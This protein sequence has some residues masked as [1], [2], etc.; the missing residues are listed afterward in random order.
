MTFVG[1]AHQRSESGVSRGR[2][3]PPEVGGLAGGGR[4]GPRRGGP[5][6]VWPDH[7]GKNSTAGGRRPTDGPIKGSERSRGASSSTTRIPLAGLSTTSEDGSGLPR[8][9]GRISERRNA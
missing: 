1:D 8:R 3:T 7:Q 2:P 5:S 6:D 4:W 9:E